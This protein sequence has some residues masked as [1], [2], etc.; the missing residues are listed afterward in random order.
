M[1]PTTANVITQQEL[2]DLAAANAAE[3]TETSKQSDASDAGALPCFHN[4]ITLCCMH[5]TSYA[6]AFV[7]AT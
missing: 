2:E 5:E 6:S 4:N 3:K 1:R 7:L